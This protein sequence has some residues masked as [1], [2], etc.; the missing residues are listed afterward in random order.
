[1]IW[2]VIEPSIGVISI[3]VPS[4]FHLF[5]RAKEHG[6]ISLFTSRNLR[7][8]GVIQDKVSEIYGAGSDKSTQDDNDCTIEGDV[9]SNE[10][11]KY[12][13]GPLAAELA[14]QGALCL[15]EA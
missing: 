9:V 10:D 13:S 1:M 3:C 12:L 7:K 2:A 14:E 4:W 8:K 5:K 6:F 11:K 15:R